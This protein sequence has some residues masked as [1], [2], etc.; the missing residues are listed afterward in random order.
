MGEKDA[1]PWRALRAQFPPNPQEKAASLALY[2]QTVRRGY[3]VISPKEALSAPLPQVLDFYFRLALFTR[4]G[5]PFSRKQSVQ[6]LSGK[7][8]VY[9]DLSAIGGWLGL[10]RIAPLFKGAAVCLN[11]YGACSQAGRRLPLSHALLDESLHDARLKEAGVA[12]EELA[13]LALQGLRRL[14]LAAGF[15]L[16]PFV[17]PQAQA[18]VKRPELFKPAAGALAFDTNSDAA[19]D[20]LAAAARHHAAAYGMDFVFYNFSGAPQPQEAWL[21]RLTQASRAAK[22]FAVLASLGQSA[23]KTLDFSLDP[24]EA[25]AAGKTF[26]ELASPQTGQ[27]LD[28]FHYGSL[29]LFSAVFRLFNRFDAFNPQDGD[30]FYGSSSLAGQTSLKDFSWEWQEAGAHGGYLLGRCKKYLAALVFAFEDQAAFAFDLKPYCHDSLFYRL[31]E[32]RF[33]CGRPLGPPQ[34]VTLAQPVLHI[35]RLKAGESRFFYMDWTG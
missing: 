1:K 31:F 34:A 29:R 20:Y 14:K 26:I 35:E 2:N 16:T 4:P 6:W 21:A 13:Q 19:A 3:A 30:F 11:F 24:K 9:V 10:L 28:A 12:L 32:E 7:D 8:I 15:E 23:D 18:A 17:A 33:F 25:L 22:S 5:R 27:A